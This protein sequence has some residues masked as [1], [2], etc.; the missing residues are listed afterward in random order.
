MVLFREELKDHLYT[1]LLIVISFWLI[2]VCLQS[3]Q[4]KENLVV[5]LYEEREREREKAK[6]TKVEENNFI[7]SILTKILI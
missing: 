5:L 2:F 6:L 1:I 4:E 7:C 3:P